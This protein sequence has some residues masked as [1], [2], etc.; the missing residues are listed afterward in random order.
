M[1]DVSDKTTDTREWYQIDKKPDYCSLGIELAAFT[2][3]WAGVLAVKRQKKKK[4]KLEMSAVTT[5]QGPSVIPAKEES[6]AKWF[7]SLEEKGRL[8]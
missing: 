2:S 3:C 6:R 1:L 4:K 8:L 5:H 7:G